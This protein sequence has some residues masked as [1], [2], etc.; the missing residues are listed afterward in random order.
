VADVT[1]TV[2][3]VGAPELGEITSSM[4]DGNSRRKVVVFGSRE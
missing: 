1:L 3:Q 2:T 4:E